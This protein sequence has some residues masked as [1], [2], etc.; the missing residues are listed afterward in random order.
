MT[1]PLPPASHEFSTETVSMAEI[2]R[3]SVTLLN[4]VR[5]VS[6]PTGA[7]GDVAVQL[8]EVASVGGHIVTAHDY[9]AGRELQCD[10]PAFDAGKPCDH[11]LAVQAVQA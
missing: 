4:T 3:L 6:Y 11:V 8:P 1:N 9:G 2:R 7:H 10:C 5:A